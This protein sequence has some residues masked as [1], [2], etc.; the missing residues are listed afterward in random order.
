[1]SIQKKAIKQFFS[2]P[3]PFANRSHLDEQPSKGARAIRRAKIHERPDWLFIL[4]AKYR[5]EDSGQRTAFNVVEDARGIS[6]A[7]LARAHL[8]PL[9][10]N[11]CNLETKEAHFINIL[12]IKALHRIDRS[13]SFGNYEKRNKLDCGLPNFIEITRIESDKL[14]NRGNLLE[15]KARMLGH[16]RDSK[17]AGAG[18]ASASVEH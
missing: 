2:F 15:F 11:G 6:S 14:L 1:V 16:L 7:H 12:Y 3:L 4:E 8:V 18:L 13:L 9:V 10:H 17:A 5:E